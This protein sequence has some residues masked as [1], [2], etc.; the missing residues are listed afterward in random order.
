MD[1]FFNQGG[2]GD[3][4]YVLIHGLGC[5]ADVWRGVSNIIEGNAAGRWIAPDLRGHGRSPWRD[6]YDAGHHAADVA[7]L[8]QD[9]KEPV[10]VGHSMGALVSIILA[11]GIFGI[12]PSATLGLGLKC[13]WP[14]DEREKL[15]TI[16]Q[17]PIR[18]FDNE[19]NAINRYLMISGLNGLINQDSAD[20]R[21][22]IREGE[23][24]FRL[25]ADPKTVTV[26]GPPNGI[27]ECARNMTPIRLACGENDAVTHL[28]G[29]R[30]MDPDAV[31]LAGLGHNCHV[32]DPEAVWDLVNEFTSVT[33]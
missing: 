15:V 19:L 27:F 18:W 12:K 16:S 20:L 8:I 6:A 5:T 22:A 14:D 11:T 24:G 28:E 1:L 25:A 13:D 30:K 29:L 32:E 9:E 31:L 7:S 21:S 17:K 3:R 2:T 26:G 10:L 4:L 23:K 33:G